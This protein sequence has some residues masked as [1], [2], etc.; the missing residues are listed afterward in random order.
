MKI[1]QIRDEDHFL[2]EFKPEDLDS[3]G[4][5]DLFQLFNVIGKFAEGKIIET[6][7]EKIPDVTPVLTKFTYDGRFFMGNPGNLDLRF[8]IEKEKD[9]SFP[10][11]SW[12]VILKISSSDIGQLGEIRLTYER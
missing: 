11:S 8:R 9:T 10:D 7:Q 1:T 12:T 5:R 6:I 3:K 4:I 2:L